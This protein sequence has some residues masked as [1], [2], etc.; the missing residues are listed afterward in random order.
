MTRPLNR[1]LIAAALFCFAVTA[2]DKARVTNDNGHPVEL[3]KHGSISC[4][5]ID[6]RLCCAP[7]K[8]RAPIRMAS[9]TKNSLALSSFG[10]ARRAGLL[11]PGIKI[12]QPVCRPQS[13]LHRSY[14]GQDDVN[15]AHSRCVRVQGKR[16]PTPVQCLQHATIHRGPDHERDQAPD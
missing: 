9:S 1:L 3:S 8:M 6:S 12:G 11:F 16:A 2:F 13:W 5:L 15:F 4:V 10:P 14:T 7:A